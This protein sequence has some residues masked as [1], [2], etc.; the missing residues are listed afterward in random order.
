MA[1]PHRARRRAVAPRR[2]ADRPRPDRCRSAPLPGLSRRPRAGADRRGGPGRGVPL[3]GRVSGRAARAAD[4]PAVLHV[5]GDPSAL[6]GAG[7]VAVVGA[8]RGT[9]YGL[10]VARS[11]GRDISAAGMTVVSGLALGVDSAAHI[12]ALSARAAPSHIEA[13]STAFAPV[14]DDGSPS[15][16]EPPPPG[17]LG[18]VGGDGSF[19]AFGPPVAAPSLGAFGPPVAAPTPRCAWVAAMLR[20]RPVRLGRPIV[21]PSGSI[22]P[23]DRSPT[24]GMTEPFGGE[25]AALTPPPDRGPPRSGRGPSTASTRIAAPVV[26]VL[27]GGADVPYPARNRRLHGTVVAAGCVDVRAAARVH[28]RTAGRSSR[29]TGSSPGSRR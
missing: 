7:S 19:G 21:A 5:A 26:A 8:R 1:A 24:P 29:A 20:P 17:A 28:R 23:L 6:L 4:P 10:E 9:P 2:R 3:L 22:N 18:A 16:S 14:R 27:A 13:P 12:G 15:A 25:A 11:L